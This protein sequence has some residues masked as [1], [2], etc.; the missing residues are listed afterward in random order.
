M[1]AYP[2][3]REAASCLVDD[4]ESWFEAHRH[5]LAGFGGRMKVVLSGILQNVV[6]RPTRKGTMMARFDIADESGSREVVA[7]SR[8]YDVIAD[9]L[10]EDAP[11][12]LV[13]EISEDGGG[14]R[15]VADRLVRWDLER[16][17]PEVAV[18]RFALEDA[19]RERLLE[20]RSRIDEYSGVTPLRLLMRREGETVVYASEQVRI[21]TAHLEEL[22][23]S[24][25]WIRTAVTVDRERLLADRGNPW[26]ARA[27]QTPA[28][29]VPF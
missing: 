9:L 3:L 13:A 2:G 1:N 17:V 18:L 24:C 20:L 15:L 26:Q 6:K 22:E 21:D 23:A 10:V 5:E 4:A 19:S 29:D 25:P 27:A 8:V 28:A 11:V 16:D 12:V 14:V 7:F